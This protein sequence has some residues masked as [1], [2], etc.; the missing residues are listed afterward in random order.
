MTPQPSIRDLLTTHLG[1][2][3]EPASVDLNANYPEPERPPALN[4][5]ELKQNLMQAIA[6]GSP[7]NDP[8]A[9]TKIENE[10]FRQKV[11][12]A[13]TNTINKDGQ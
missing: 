3:K 10:A 6:N 13:L 1:N 2:I 9:Q 12:E 8:T 5:P 11:V 7:Q 4:G